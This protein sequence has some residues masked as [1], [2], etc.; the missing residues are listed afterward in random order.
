ME[1]T[2]DATIKTARRGTE[3]AGSEQGLL[4]ER[5]VAPVRGMDR[6]PA[7]R[8]ARGGGS[9][10]TYLGLR[11][12]H[13]ARALTMEVRRWL[14]SIAAPGGP[15]EAALRFALGACSREA[16]SRIVEGWSLRQ[17]RGA[18]AWHLAAAGAA[19]DGAGM[20]VQLAIEEGR[21]DRERGAAWAARYEAL[22]RGLGAL[23][24]ALAGPSHS[25]REPSARFPARRMA[26]AG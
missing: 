1:A 5:P 3:G 7:Q 22:A 25:C 21:L 4:F 23:R 19:A 24:R 20:W 26:A 6:A 16:L 18:W 8:G 14:E 10:G 13:E 17:D 9:R 12:Y 11:V 2:M 15:E